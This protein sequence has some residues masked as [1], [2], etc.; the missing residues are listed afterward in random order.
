MFS[1][2]GQ[3][4]RLSFPAFPWQA[5]LSSLA[6]C[7]PQLKPLPP[8]TPLQGP[9]YCTGPQQPPPTLSPTF[10]FKKLTPPLSLWVFIAPTYVQPVWVSVSHSN[11][12]CLCLTVTL[13]TVSSLA[14]CLYLEISVLASV[15]HVPQSSMFVS[16]HFLCS[17]DFSLSLLSLMSLPAPPLS[18]LPCSSLN[19]PD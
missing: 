16:V 18:F 5:S 2:Q 14:V 1:G 17:T 13:C 7:Q 8:P 6:A 3:P 9:G 11:T 19:P 10:L 12:R 4:S 15:W